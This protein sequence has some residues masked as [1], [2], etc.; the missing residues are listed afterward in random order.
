MSSSRSGIGLVLA[1]FLLAV[2]YPLP[3]A[4]AVV[5][6]SEADAG[7]TKTVLRGDK[8]ELQI[9]GNPTTGFSWKLASIDGNAVRTFHEIRYKPHRPGLP[10]APGVFVATFRAVSPGTSTIN[11]QYLRPWEKNTPPAKTYA[12][13]IIVK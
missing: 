1:A 10:G 7:Q 2:A 5:R 6:L 8:L 11:M 13:T 3:A 9:G 12:V 4:S